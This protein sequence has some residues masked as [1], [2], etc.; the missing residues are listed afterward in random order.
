M[1]SS[2]QPE[3][4]ADS[5]RYEDLGP[6]PEIQDTVIFG[7]LSEEDRAAVL[8]PVWPTRAQY[9]GWDGPRQE[10]KDGH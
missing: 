2:H 10:V 8:R 7:L 1:C 5:Q 3:N 9:G 4:G 6:G